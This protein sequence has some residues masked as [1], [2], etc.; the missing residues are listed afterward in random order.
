MGNLSLTTFIRDKN[1]ELDENYKPV[2][3]TSE[4]PLDDPNAYITTKL[5]YSQVP[6]IIGPRRGLSLLQLHDQ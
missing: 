4:T 6:I 5:E 2:E 1:S 3:N